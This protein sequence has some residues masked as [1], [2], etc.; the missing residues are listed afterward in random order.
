MS[1]SA[2]PLAGR[3]IVITRPAHQAGP[4]ADMVRAQGAH[5]ILFPTIEIVEPHDLRPFLAVVDRLEEFDL[6]VFVSPNAVMKAFDTM[7]AQRRLP[8][9]LAIAAAMFR[10]VRRMMESHLREEHPAWDLARIDA[11]ILRRF[12]HGTG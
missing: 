10:S 11:E 5:V 7:S 6:A 12:G 4:L 9:R 2:A 3:G 8:E 1:E